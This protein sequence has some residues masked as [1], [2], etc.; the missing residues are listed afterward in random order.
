M[1]LPDNRMTFLMIFFTE[2]HQEYEA[3]AAKIN[4]AE[5]RRFQALVLQTRRRQQMQQQQ[6]QRNQ[7]LQQQQQRNELLQQQQQQFRNMSRVGGIRQQP[8]STG[9]RI[10]SVSSLSA[11]R[12]RPIPPSVNL[13]SSITISR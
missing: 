3:R 9:L 7:L 10:S 11:G 13:P 4:E 6:Q 2:V 5:E 1:D 12:S 8:S